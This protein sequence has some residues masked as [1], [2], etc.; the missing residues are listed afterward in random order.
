M[1]L[2]TQNRRNIERI[3]LS[4][5]IIAR[6]GTTSVVL[7]DISTRGARVEHHVSLATNARLRLTFTWDGDQLAIDCVVTRCKLDRFSKEGGGLT[8]Y[9]SGLAFDNAV[10][11]SA[12][13]LR[14]LV[15]THIERA[16]Y[17]QKANA[18]GIMPDS[19]EHMPIF[20]GGV[21]TRS[22]QEVKDA[23]SSS[24]A[25]PAT[26]I[27][28]DSGFVVYRLDGNYWTKKQ[29]QDPE[30]PDD[31]FTLSALEDPSQVALLCETYWRAGHEGRSMIRLLAQ[32]SLEGEGISRGRFEP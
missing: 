27:I 13:H 18:R 11:D 19:I 29:T 6:L 30:Q 16:L 25:L 10:G 23:V 21:L 3:R 31:G 7:V 22:Q 17:E 20:R 28:R 1:K 5:P 4:E 14:R 2:P 32:I 8:V 12:K 9:H 26:R 15:L 24:I